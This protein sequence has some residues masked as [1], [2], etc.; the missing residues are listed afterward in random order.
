[1]TGGIVATGLVF[2]PAAPFFLFMHGKD[3]TIP[4]GAEVTA[5]TNGRLELDAAT[6][7][8]AGTPI[9]NSSVTTTMATG[10]NTTLEISSTPSAAEI[11]LDGNFVGYTPSSM[12]VSPGDHTIKLTKTG[13]T[14]WERNLKT[15]TGTVKISPELAVIIP[16]QPKTET[17]ETK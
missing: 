15:S 13:Y 7:Q 14:S 12:G 17:A 4:K 1:M 6:F 10:S 16:D 8:A 9:A 3:V 5:Y 11:E 2:F